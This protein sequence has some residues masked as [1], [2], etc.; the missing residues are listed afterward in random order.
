MLCFEAETG[1]ARAHVREAKVR[2]L[3]AFC[4]TNHVATASSLRALVLVLVR[5]RVR[6]REVE[7]AAP[8]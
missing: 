2:P 5:E 1:G 8:D 3:V 6:V 7:Q 4:E